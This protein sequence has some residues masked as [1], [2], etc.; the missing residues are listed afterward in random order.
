MPS[1]QCTKLKKS[2][3]HKHAETVKSRAKCGRKAQPP[4]C[5]VIAMCI[6]TTI[7]ASSNSHVTPLCGQSIS[8]GWAH[9]R[10]QSSLLQLASP[11]INFTVEIWKPNFSISNLRK[12]EVHVSN[13]LAVQDWTA[14]HSHSRVA[15]SSR[16]LWV[17]K[18]W[19][20]CLILLRREKAWHWWFRGN[21]LSFERYLQG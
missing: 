10:A 21:L 3:K 17:R 4:F 18:I 9:G 15:A 19:K 11:E 8:S 16:F 2:L 1:V 12:M 14:A 6:C 5:A 13:H 20:H 7:F